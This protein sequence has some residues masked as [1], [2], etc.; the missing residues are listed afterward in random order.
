MVMT[1]R[2]IPMNYCTPEAVGI[3]SAD[4][5]KFNQKLEER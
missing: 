4:V 5:L 1:K 3:S 2:S